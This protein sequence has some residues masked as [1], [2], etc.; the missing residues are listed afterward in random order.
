MLYIYVKGFQKDCIIDVNKYF[1]FRKKKDWF[2]EESVKKII[3]GIDDTIAVKDEYL[4]SPVFGGMA[5]ERLSGGCKAVIMLDVIDNINIYATKCGDNCAKYIQ[6]IAES[7]DIRITL[8]HP[9]IF[10]DDVHAVFIDSNKEV[11]SYREYIE[12][13]YRLWHEQE[14]EDK[15][16]YIASGGIVNES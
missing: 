13:F 3:K 10:G 5:P 14:E 15:L 9:M 7:K 1:N 16:K 12:E 4:E 6:E 11:H 8:H 2:N